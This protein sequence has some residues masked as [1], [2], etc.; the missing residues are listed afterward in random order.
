MTPEKK[1]FPHRIEQTMAE[2]TDNSWFSTF[3]ALLESP[4]Q[5]KPEEREKIT[6]TSQEVLG[7]NFWRTIGEIGNNFE[8]LKAISSQPKTALNAYDQILDTIDRVISTPPSQDQPS[9]LHLQQL[10]IKASFAGALYCWAY[11]NEGQKT[12]ELFAHSP[13]AKVDYR[14]VWEKEIA[15]LTKIDKTID[16]AAEVLKKSFRISNVKAEENLNRWF[17]IFSAEVA[18]ASLPNK[19]TKKEIKRIPPFF[20]RLI[21]LSYIAASLSSSGTTKIDQET[22]R[23]ALVQEKPVVLSVGFDPT[24]EEEERQRMEQEM[25][26]PPPT[27]YREITDPFEQGKWFEQAKTQTTVPSEVPHKITTTT[28]GKG[29]KTGPAPEISIE[30]NEAFHVVEPGDWLSKIV[31]EYWDAEGPMVSRFSRVLLMINPH[32]GN[33]PNKIEVGKRVFIYPDQMKGKF[34]EVLAFLLEG[35][36]KLDDLRKLIKDLAIPTIDSQNESVSASEKGEWVIYENKEQLTLEEILR[37]YFGA[38]GEK[39]L[40]LINRIN[41]MKMLG[42]DVVPLLVLPPL[43]WL[44]FEIENNSLPPAIVIPPIPISSQPPIEQPKVKENSP[45]PP[46]TAVP[47]ASVETTYIV[48]KGDNLSA[49]A[50]RY[51]TTV[52]ALVADNGI[53]NHNKIFVGQKLRIPGKEVSVKS[54]YKELPKELEKYLG[55]RWATWEEIP[56]ELRQWLTGIVVEETSVRRVPAWAIFSIMSAEQLGGFRLTSR[57]GAASDVEPLGI[58]PGWELT[59]F[60]TKQERFDFRKQVAMVSERLVVNGLSV[61][62]LNKIGEEAYREKLE[63]YLCKHNAGEGRN[64]GPDTADR[65]ISAPGTKRTVQNYVDDGSQTAKD[66]TKNPTTLQNDTQEVIADKVVQETDKKLGVTPAKEE[67]KAV[68]G[69]KDP[70]AVVNGEKPLE[71]AV[72]EA[73][74]K[75]VEAARQKLEKEVKKIVQGENVS[76]QDEPKASAALQTKGITPPEP[77]KPEAEKPKII[78]PP[79]EELSRIQTSAQKSLC[80]PVPAEEIVAALKASGNDPEKAI[81]YFESSPETTICQ[82][83]KESWKKATGKEALTSQARVVAEEAMKVWGGQDP[84]IL[85]YP[86]IEAAKKRV[87]EIFGKKNENEKKK[88]EENKKPTEP[89]SK[90]FDTERKVRLPQVG[91]PYQSGNLKLRDNVGTN[92]GKL[93]DYEVHGNRNYTGV[94][95]WL[96]QDFQTDS[97]DKTVVSPIDGVA[98]SGWDPK[99]GYYISVRGTGIYE[100]LH[101]RIIHLAGK[102]AGGQINRGQSI[103]KEGPQVH[104][105]IITL[106]GDGG[107]NASAKDVPFSLLLTE[108]QKPKSKYQAGSYTELY[109]PGDDYFKWFE[110][111]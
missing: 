10:V 88:E 51:G 84:H 19:V 109:S 82:Q 15:V 80:R 44:S 39:S 62:T 1:I 4:K 65:G 102:T 101:V 74:E 93:N 32:L 12:C 18:N 67:A 94:P 90:V 14:D 99:A 5:F 61:D 33:D 28:T 41:H 47:T 36:G 68:V 106:W 49:I 70:K 77:V 79:K 23:K 25:A 71:T 56:E 103:S 110:S 78:A 60:G 85:N 27:T 73:V 13:I 50:R 40:A 9:F 48:K 86:Q 52:Q 30:K 63:I 107:F 69:E 6:K 24:K 46:K 54:V 3:F 89:L 55:G 45:E 83:A 111:K 43:G 108:D 100:G 31:K 105:H 76:K 22:L 95:S 42:Q 92:S 72:K 21:A 64:C 87:E 8:G 2:I 17:G 81:Q 34:A 37:L 11:K 57:S 53:A 75:Q 38:F 29:G 35:K 7:I 58:T 66:L 97:P 91:Q 104:L 16:G 26:G 96:G 98:E 59:Y 20:Y